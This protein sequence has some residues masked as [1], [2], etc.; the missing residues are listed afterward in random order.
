MNVCIFLFYPTEN[1]TEKIGDF[2]SSNA[3]SERIE[4]IATKLDQKSRVIGNWIHL[5]RQFKIS[6]EKLKEIE[7]GLF[8]PAVAL[9]E[10]L[11]LK[12]EDLTVEK[13]YNEV[14][15]LNRGDVLNKLEPFRRGRFC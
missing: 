15:I 10:Y 14:K 13:F 3:N 11:F 5:G 1:S 6:D 7:Y 2:A 8:N 9:M 4:A 12:Q